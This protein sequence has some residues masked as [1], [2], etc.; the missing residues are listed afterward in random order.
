MADTAGLLTR[1]RRLLP[2]LENTPNHC[3]SRHFR[4][5]RPFL[6]TS[7]DFP[8]AGLPVVNSTAAF[9]APQSGSFYPSSSSVPCSFAACSLPWPLDIAGN[10]CVR[11]SFG[12]DT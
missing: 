8:N 3:N 5:S 11:K 10:F 1:F 2:A 6:E 4:N 7:R 9:A 12:S